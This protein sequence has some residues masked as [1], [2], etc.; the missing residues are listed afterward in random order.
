M[1]IQTPRANTTHPMILVAAT[2]VT[3][4]SL[5]GLA[6]LFGWLPAG[7]AAPATTV[8]PVAQL[9]GNPADAGASPPAAMPAA[10]PEKSAAPSARSEASA[11]APVAEARPARRAAVHPAA[12]TKTASTTMPPPPPR[13]DYGG[14]GA[15]PVAADAGNAPINDSGIYAENGRSAPPLCRE[16]GTV[17]SV[18]EI[19]QEG[20][21]GPLGAIAGGVLGGVLGHQVGNGRGRDVATVVGALGGAFAGHTVEKNVRSTRQ[22]QITVRFDDGSRRTVTET[23]PPQWQNGDRVRLDNERLSRL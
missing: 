6:A 23:N 12:V 9:A 7:G 17:E 21:G 16:C 3:A 22:Y 13:A 5:A 18:R 11:P 20:Q 19:A 4:L 14:R 8:A 1:E 2:A 10:A 15:T